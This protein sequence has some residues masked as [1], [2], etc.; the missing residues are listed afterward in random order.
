MVNGKPPGGCVAGGYEK[1]INKT[2][3]A[4]EGAPG[5]P[6]DLRRAR[7]SGIL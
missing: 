1:R 3:T 5:P 7:V 4:G 6:S 2:S